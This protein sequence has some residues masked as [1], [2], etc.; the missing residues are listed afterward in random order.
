MAAW[1]MELSPPTQELSFHSRFFCMAIFRARFSCFSFWLLCCRKR[2]YSIAFLRIADLLSCQWAG[3]VQL[4]FRANPPRL[5]HQ[6][7]LP[8][9]P[10]CPPP[11]P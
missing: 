6:P 3:T 7:L 11:G 4:K 9:W 1:G 8:P 5:P 2:M 10:R